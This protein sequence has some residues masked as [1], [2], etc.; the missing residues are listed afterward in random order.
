MPVVLHMF[1]LASQANLL[2][3]LDLSKSHNGVFPWVQ[4]VLDDGKILNINGLYF[5]NQ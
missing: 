3:E 5:V 1:P 4:S 2:F